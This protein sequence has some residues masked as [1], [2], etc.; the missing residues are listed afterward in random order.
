MQFRTIFYKDLK[1]LFKQKAV[2]FTLLMPAIIIITFGLLPLVL[3]PS[4]TFVIDI[5]M[6]DEG[7][8]LSNNETLNIGEKIYEE[9]EMEFAKDGQ[10][11]LN[12]LS[13]FDEFKESENGI[14]IPANF[15]HVANL[16]RV[17]TYYFV[18]SDSNFLSQSVI[19]GTV[20]GIIERV[21]TR[22]LVPE[23]VPV[24]DSQQYLKSTQIGDN[25]E[26]KNRGAIAFPLAYMAFLIL[27]MGSSTMRMTGFSAEKEAGMIELLLIN[28]KFRRELVL[29][30]LVLGMLYG[31]LSILSY[32]VGVGIVILL[33]MGSSGG[34]ATEL[35]SFVIPGD[36]FKV[37]SILAIILMFVIL[38]FMSMQIL[39]AMQLSMGREA[40]DKFGGMTLT[41][42]TI[43]FY[44]TSLSDPLAES[45]IQ[46]L[47][48]FFWPFKLA[49]N[50]IFKEQPMGSLFYGWLILT[51]NIYLVRSQVKSIQKETILFE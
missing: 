31:L 50:L 2:I 34:S 32:I 22:E 24:A 49:L 10:L 46:I 25:G 1:A 39:M 42:M 4:T 29:S 36:L 35:L 18:M 47:N 38:S 13:S 48:P 8:V 12:N 51:F 43:M 41:I 21:V 20:H 23:G 28:V 17:A 44:I 26:A 16:T 30:K 14:W 37:H 9:L 19:E 40:G 11:A 15:T 27:I 3:D 5:L 6:E 7:I 33:N 45:P